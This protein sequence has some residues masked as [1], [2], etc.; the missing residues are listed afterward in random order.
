MEMSPWFV[1]S[2]SRKVIAG[3]GSR[4]VSIPKVLVELVSRYEEKR[5]PCAYPIYCIGPEPV[6]IAN[7]VLKSAFS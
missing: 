6:N 4:K 5:R 7:P 1:L 2:G 3:L